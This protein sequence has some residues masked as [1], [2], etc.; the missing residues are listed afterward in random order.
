MSHPFNEDYFLRGKETGISNY[1]D[2]RWRPELTLP[3]A[4]KIMD[5]LDIDMGNTL[6]DYGCAR[7]FYVRA[8]RELYIESYGYDISEWA[9]QNCDESVRDF[10]TNDL[11]EC[12]ER[13][14]DWIFSKDTF[15][16]IDPTALRDLIVKLMHRSESGMLFIVPLTEL[17]GGQF[18]YA[19]D[20]RDKTHIIRWTLESWVKFVSAICWGKF[21][22]SGSYFIPGI[23]PTIDEFPH[24]SGFITCKRI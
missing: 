1:T 10:V 22:V 6:L 23:K 9:I 21:I 3:T 14:Y 4:G 20:N 19:P 16:H 8:F 7:G 13:K 15:E 24:S 5:Y 11:S 12:I 2:Y 18:I 17:D